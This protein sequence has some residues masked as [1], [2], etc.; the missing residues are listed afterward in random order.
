M[1]PQSTKLFAKDGLGLLGPVVTFSKRD[2]PVR[3][4][5][6]PAPPTPCSTDPGGPHRIPSALSVVCGRVSPDPS[7]YLRDP[8][9]LCIVRPD[10]RGTLRPETEDVRGVLG[11][12]N[13]M[14]WI[15]SRGAH[16]APPVTTISPRSTAPGSQ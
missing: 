4:L 15:V 13:P 14:T 12:V 1:R 6:P 11:A 10:K 9:F 2:R 7:R 8:L 5:D 16:A 3:S